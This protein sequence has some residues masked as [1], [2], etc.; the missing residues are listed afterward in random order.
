MNKDN[1]TST[2]FN[3]DKMKISKLSKVSIVFLVLQF[4]V[5]TFACI[6]W[7]IPNIN[8]ISFQKATNIFYFFPWI[9]ISL[10]LAIVSRVKYKDSASGVMIIVNVG[11]IV[12]LIMGIT[13]IIIVIFALFWALINSLL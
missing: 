10:V 4:V 12:S 3:N 7:G 8:E 13:I 11:I 5:P 6:F 2:I 1:Q 9:L